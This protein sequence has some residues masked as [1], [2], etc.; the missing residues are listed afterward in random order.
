MAYNWTYLKEEKV[1]GK[2]L[3]DLL[4]PYLQ[5]SDTVL[6]VD[7]GYSPMAELFIKGGYRLFGFDVNAEP[8]AY[9][10]RTQPQGDWHIQPDSMANYSGCTVFLLLGVTTPLYPIYSSTYLQSLE[11]LLEANRP[12]VVL[13]ESADAADQ[14]LYIQVCQLL[15]RYGYTKK[16][17]RQYDAK[18][19]QASLRHCTLWLKVWDYDYWRHKFWTAQNLNQV[20]ADF[21]KAAGIALKPLKIVDLQ[22]PDLHKH[23]NR[24]LRD[25]I[26]NEDQAKDLL[27]TGF[28]DGRFAFHM[29]LLGYRVHGIEPY[30]NAVAKAK[31]LQK[32]LPAD[33]ASRFQFDV[34]FAEDL[35][36]LP[37]YD[38]TVNFCLEHVRDPAHV[39][40]EA[41][42][43][44]RTAAYFTPPIGRGCD[45]PA[46]LY[47]FQ[48]PDLQQLIPKGW[49]AQ[50][51]RVKFNDS[52]PRPNCFVMKVTKNA[53]QPSSR[54]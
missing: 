43:H 54:P 1:R 37:V 34:G 14:E 21:Y 8:I 5:P 3:F 13:A 39:V 28:W 24:V 2:F 17:Y 32:T 49:T 41:L 50:Y 18:L 33:V 30:V 40:T 15:S 48:E 31:Q 44:T 20:H 4:Q 19:Q 47:H 6:D 22:P 9:L 16:E 26:V 12:R 38:V 27:V 46:H 29:G 25:L 53:I 52:S 10:K 42:Q 45:S 11:R 36:G 35:T 7:C 23:K 51:H